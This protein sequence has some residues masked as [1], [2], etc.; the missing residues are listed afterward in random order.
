[1]KDFTVPKNTTR[2]TWDVSFGHS[3]GLCVD[4]TEGDYD[5]AELQLG[6]FYS[7]A[8]GTATTPKV[9]P[10]ETWVWLPGYQE[11]FWGPAMTDSYSTTLVKG[12]ARI[13]MG[14]EGHE[15]LG[16][17]FDFY[18]GYIYGYHR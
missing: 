13:V 7:G 10:S 5:C 8:F 2:W 4:V 17:Y 1:M 11:L 3:R 12:K 18:D 15:E 14:T 9:F 6:A 16:S